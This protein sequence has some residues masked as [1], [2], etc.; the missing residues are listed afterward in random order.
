[1]LLLFHRHARVFIR[2]TMGLEPSQ[3]MQVF[4]VGDRIEL[5]LVRN[6]REM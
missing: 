6:A 1:M 3:K 2:E 5:V 4:L